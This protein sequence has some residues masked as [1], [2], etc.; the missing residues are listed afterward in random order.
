M[1]DLSEVPTP[2]AYG[3]RVAQESGKVMLHAW[4]GCGHLGGLAGGQHGWNA[5]G[6]VKLGQLIAA[7][8]SVLGG[9]GIAGLGRHGVT[10][11]LSGVVPL[12]CGTAQCLYWQRAQAMMNSRQNRGKPVEIDLQQPKLNNLH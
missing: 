6:A 10:L 7:D 9:A 5:N 12:D 4:R 2:L 3:M 11:V 1:M 8:H